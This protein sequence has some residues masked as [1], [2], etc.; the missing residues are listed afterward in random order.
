VVLPFPWTKIIKGDQNTGG[1][2]LMYEKEFENSLGEGKGGP[3]T[4]RERG[5][6]LRTGRGE[7]ETKGGTASPHKFNFDRQR[8]FKLK[9]GKKRLV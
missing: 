5:T 2:S 7:W 6:L 1:R 3:A 8:R 9:F 4:G